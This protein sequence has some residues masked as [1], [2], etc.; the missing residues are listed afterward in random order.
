MFGRFRSSANTPAAVDCGHCRI[1]S[2]MAKASA[3]PRIEALAR[4]SRNIS[5]TVSLRLAS[6]YALGARRQRARDGKSIEHQGGAKELSTAKAGG[7]EPSTVSGAGGVVN[8]R[9]G[10]RLVNSTRGRRSCE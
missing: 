9:A 6:A 7:V 4:R 3:R 1:A 5:L 8:A 10:R 2:S